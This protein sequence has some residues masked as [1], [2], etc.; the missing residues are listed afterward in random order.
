MKTIEELFTEPEIDFLK[1]TL[2]R[3]KLAIEKERFDLQNM[4]NLYLEQIHIK[5]KT[6]F[7]LNTQTVD[8]NKVNLKKSTLIK[9]INDCDDFSIES[10]YDGSECTLITYNIIPESDDIYNDRLCVIGKDIL[11]REKA[12]LSRLR[13]LEI[14]QIL[15]EKTH[16]RIKRGRPKGKTNNVVRILR[17]IE[18]GGWTHFIDDFIEEIE[19]P[20]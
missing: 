20:F 5:N 15:I 6:H 3:R 2:E 16:K 10:G 4:D 13:K 7:F 11:K 12:K 19:H 8:I 17:D 18:I 1:K 9:A 14:R